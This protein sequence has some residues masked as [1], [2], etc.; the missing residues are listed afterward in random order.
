MIPFPAAYPTS[1]HAI[2]SVRPR[3]RHHAI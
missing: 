1:L 3:I 2:H